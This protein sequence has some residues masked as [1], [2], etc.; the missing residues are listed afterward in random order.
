[1]KTARLFQVL[2]LLF[3]L[4][5]LTIVGCSYTTNNNSSAGNENGA[6]GSTNSV[7]SPGR[8]IP[9]GS[10][11]SEDPNG[12]E[13]ANG[14]CPKDCVSEVCV[15]K[16]DQ[17]NLAQCIPESDVLY[18]NV[19]DENCENGKEGTGTK[20][21]PFCEIQKA[22]DEAIKAKKPY[23]SVKASYRDH[24]R[25]SRKADYSTIKIS[26]GSVTMLGPW[27]N[28]TL[29]SNEDPKDRA[30][31]I[32]FKD[33]AIVGYK[34][35]EVISLEVSGDASVTF[36]GFHFTGS[37][38]C[39]SVNASL[40]IRHSLLQSKDLQA[41]E[42]IDDKNQIISKDRIL[43][44]P[45]KKIT[46]ENSD[47]REAGRGKASIHI[48]D[49]T[50]YRIVNSIIAHSPTG[51]ILEKNSAGVFEFNTVTVHDK[52]GIDCG[53][54]GSKKLIK[55][56]IVVQNNGG[57]GDDQFTSLCEFEAVVAGKNEKNTDSKL[58]IKFPEFEIGDFRL[59]EN[60]GQNKDCC[61]N[62]ATP[63]PEI[64]IDFFE[65]IRPKGGLPDIG[66]QEVE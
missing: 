23:V 43:A 19:R 4:S 45:C 47:I 55:N 51:V 64:K 40:E 7:N 62:K 57:T 49:M 50:T 28:R 65:N 3:I 30:N 48:G 39:S 36:D 1:M 24:A 61:I 13:S 52:K 18:V 15:T 31:F 11:G 25:D 37:V 10:N 29:K 59:Q 2:I 54:V 60:S 66:F 26:T 46:I 21:S 8:N 5:T 34:E 63:D 44:S 58:I 42:G 27:A 6:T 17:P 22:V 38:V 14:G 33:I 56:S 32:S 35:N 20:T 41:L 16:P 12:A 53:D 9:D